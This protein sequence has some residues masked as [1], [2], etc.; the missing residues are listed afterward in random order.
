MTGLSVLMLMSSSTGDGK[1][2]LNN[3]KRWKYQ[4]STRMKK[5]HRKRQWCFFSEYRIVYYDDNIVRFSYEDYAHGAKTSY[6]TL[7][8]YTWVANV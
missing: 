2:Y 6:M 8:G 3:L 1:E 5:V 4:V 7:M